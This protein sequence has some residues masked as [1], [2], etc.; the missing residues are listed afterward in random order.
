[1]TPI[2]SD[3]RTMVGSNVQWGWEEAC[4]G[5]V[6]DVMVARDAG[7]ISIRTCQGGRSPGWFLDKKDIHRV[8]MKRCE[9]SQMALAHINGEKVERVRLIRHEEE[10]GQEQAHHQHKPIGQQRCE[11]K[12]HQQFC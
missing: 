7:R 4:P 8:I 9:K 12:G 11:G 1:M 6:G 10:G 2:D 3:M 5:R